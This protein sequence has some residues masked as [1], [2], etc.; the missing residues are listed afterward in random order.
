MLDHVNSSASEVLQLGLSTPDLSEMSQ[1][2]QSAVLKTE[3]SEKED[4]EPDSL[5]V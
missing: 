1:G 5:F 4:M 3:I 2:L